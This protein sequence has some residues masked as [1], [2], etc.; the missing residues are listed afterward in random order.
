MGDGV[1]TPVILRVGA[2]V[3]LAPLVVL[4]VWIWA[5]LSRP[6]PVLVL[7]GFQMYVLAPAWIV[8]VAALV[9]REWAIAALA[10][11]VAVSHLA[12][13]LPAATADEVPT[14]VADAPTF[15]MF[16]AN[17]RYDNPQKDDVAR[18]VLAADADVVILNEMTPEQRAALQ[19]AGVYDRYPTRM[20][21]E[22][23]P[24]GEMLL[25]RLTA[26][27]VFNANLGGS[28]VP[29][30]T[31]SVADASLRVYAVHVNAPKSSAQ[32]HVWR[33]NLDGIGGSTEARG[34]MPEVYAGDFNSAPWH[35]PY[36]DLLDRGLTDAHDAM[37]QGL[38][39]SW[40]PHLPVLDLLGPIMRLDHALFTPGVFPVSLDDVEVPGSDHRG[41]EITLA[42]EP[43]PR[44]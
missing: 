11:I 20:Y 1:T 29:T 37:G 19:D 28:R 40:T 36:R 34:T 24:F 16:V 22:G 35:G 4:T 32:R 30:A 39:R 17:V 6:S 25:T 26:R 9:T 10:T 21:T 15:S 12:F 43:S 13:C 31:V 38:S 14:W 18:Q 33:R 42:V 2:L 8:L 27:D 7:E 3:V 44:S 5:G 41:F 23:R